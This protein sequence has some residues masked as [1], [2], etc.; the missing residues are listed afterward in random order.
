MNLCQISAICQH[1]R[2]RCRVWGS[3]LKCECPSDI[4]DCVPGINQCQGNP[5]L[6][7]DEGKLCIELDDRK[8]GWIMGSEVEGKG[9]TCMSKKTAEILR[10]TT[11]Y[12]YVPAGKDIE[13]VEKIQPR[14]DL[15][16]CC[17][18]MMT[19]AGGN[20]THGTI[21]SYR[22]CYCFV[23]FRK[24]LL[25]LFS[26]A[27]KATVQ[28]IVKV[29]DSI[30]FCEM[31]DGVK[32]HPSRPWTCRKGDLISSSIAH[33]KINCKSG[34]LLPI[35]ERACSKRQCKPP[36]YQKHLLIAD[37]PRNEESSLCKPVKGLSVEC[38]KRGTHTR[39]VCEA[40]PKISGFTDRCR[41]QFWPS[42]WNKFLTTTPSRRVNATKKPSI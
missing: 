7:E 32:C 14:D 37:V 17:Y 6:C 18:R 30:T 5:G 40:N 38:A 3:E 9:Y 42:R 27:Y 8:K 31:D 35:W 34:P 2:A 15:D 22:P 16:M 23:E 33:C 1:E 28:A 39:C 25:Q 11:H 29:V 36:H 12:C 21:F 20:T 10:V 19:C 24:C 4:P 26:V 13:R 41:C